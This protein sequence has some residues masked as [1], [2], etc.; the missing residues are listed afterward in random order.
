VIYRNLDLDSDIINP[1]IKF[2]RFRD[3]R[4]HGRS[5]MLYAK[6]EIDKSAESIELG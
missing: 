2:V 1:C 3:G 6:K 5:L 4:A